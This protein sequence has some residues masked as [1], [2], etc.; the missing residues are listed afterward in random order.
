MVR[1]GSHMLLFCPVANKLALF[2]LQLKPFSYR[3]RRLYGIPKVK[4]HTNIVQPTNV[5]IG[6]ACTCTV[7]VR[8]CTSLSAKSR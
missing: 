7:L 3:R 5:D 2:G 1:E 6:T 4:S 8:H